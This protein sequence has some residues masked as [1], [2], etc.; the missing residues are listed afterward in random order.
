MALRSKLSFSEEIRSALDADF[1][2]RDMQVDPRE[3]MLKLDQVVN[4]HARLGDLE[5]WKMNKGE[6]VDD[7]FT[8]SF[9]WLTVTDPSNKMPSY[10]Q[11]PAT[12]VALDTNRGIDQVYFKNDF[13]AVKKKYFDPVIITSF[14]DLS[15]Y[16][17]TLGGELHGRIS[18]YPKDG[19]L[20][21]DRGNINATY[22][23]IGIRLV[24]R[25]AS[26][27]G[28]ND[29]YPIPADR[30]HIIIDSVIKF[31]RDK[32]AQATDHI[33]DTIDQP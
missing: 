25:D 17:N 27:L 18:C 20:V 5:N 30:Q 19:Y 16:R 6:F 29:P 10:V 31:F 14:K 2:T 8:T 22:G 4:E 9:E 13:S 15:S 32:L 26:Y 24:V 1:G 12:P 23:D 7:T 28:D 3:I 33:R 21:F 11:L